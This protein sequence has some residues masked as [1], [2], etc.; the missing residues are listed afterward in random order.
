MYNVSVKV[1]SHVIEMLDSYAKK[2]GLNRSVIIRRAIEKFLQERSK[3]KPNFEKE[4]SKQ[5]PNFEDRL[6]IDIKV[7]SF[8]VESDFLRRLDMY[9]I[10]SRLDRSVIIRAAIME[11]LKEEEDRVTVPTAKVEKVYKIGG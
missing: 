7:L 9:A 5:K 10:N 11:L 8:K 2:H 4:K 6:Q 3:Q 1:E